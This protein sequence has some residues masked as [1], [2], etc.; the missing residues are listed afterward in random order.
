[1]E[2]NV[3]RLLPGYKKQSR[4]MRTGYFWKKVKEAIITMDMI[5]ETGVAEIKTTGWARL[6]LFPGNMD[7]GRYFSDIRRDLL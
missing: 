2:R 7:G 6:I 1:M 5:G 3:N 4:K